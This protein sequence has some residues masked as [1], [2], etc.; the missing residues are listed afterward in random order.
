MSV[1]TALPPPPRAE[2][3]TREEV[4]AQLRIKPQTLYAYVSRGLI[5][6]VPQPGG[7]SHFYLADD[8]ERIRLKSAARAGLGAVAASAMRWGEPV[9]TTSITQITE[10][11][12][13]YRSRL[14]ADLVRSGASF[15]AV[16]DLLWQ[17]TWID[18]SSWNAADTPAE[19]ISQLAQTGRLHPSP[20]IVQR[21]IVTIALLGTALG[22][23]QERTRS[24]TTVVLLARQAIRTLAGVF[25]FLGP[26]ERYSVLRPS[27][28]IA[29]GLAR[30]LGIEPAPQALRALNAFLVLDADHELTSSTFAA[31]VAA[32]GAADI[33]ACLGA[34]LNVHYSSL[35]GTRADLVE[36]MFD[37]RGAPGS[38]IARVSELI[39][40]GQSVPGFNH[41]AYPHGDPR[42]RMLIELA[43]ETGHGKRAVRALAETVEL[44]EQE[45]RLL[46]AFEIG[47]V[48]LCRALGLPPQTASGLRS[49]GRSAGWVAHVIEQRLAAFMIRPRAR[50]VG[51]GTLPSL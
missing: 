18:C 26:R 25:G 21:M 45:F 13:R 39:R 10:E 15:E 22:S 2:Y 7:R 20:H 27:E 12:P 8:I 11:G 38:G 1:R 3:L 4:L 37:A 40:S 29:S 19:V 35:T 9:I 6:S 32:S 36:A 46:P 28:S 33:H 14:A 43:L 47:A 34:A 16:A 17:G 51:P 48:M 41:P 44:I 42:A 23:M 30:A 49:L 31:R 50:Y 5:R 24:G